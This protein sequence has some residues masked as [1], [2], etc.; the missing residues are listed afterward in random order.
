ME[1]QFEEISEKNKQLLDQIA[2]VGVLK[3]ETRGLELKLEEKLTSKF[4]G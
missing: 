4:H 1:K 2:G 3:A